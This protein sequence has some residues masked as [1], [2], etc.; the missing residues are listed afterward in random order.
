MDPL[1]PS[2]NWYHLLYHVAFASFVKWDKTAKAWSRE[3]KS[4]LVEFCIAASQGDLHI[5]PLGDWL[6]H[7]SLQLNWVSL[8]ALEHAMPFQNVQSQENLLLVSQFGWLITFGFE[9]VGAHFM[10][11]ARKLSNLSWADRDKLPTGIG[12]SCPWTCFN[13]RYSSLKFSRMFE[14]IRSVRDKTLD[15]ATW[16]T[17]RLSTRMTTSGAGFRTIGVL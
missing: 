10:I 16:V 8:R 14:S 15:I 4:G 9:C 13:W 11:D 2:M 5:I 6:S 3:K 17:Q 12:K 1:F 7:G